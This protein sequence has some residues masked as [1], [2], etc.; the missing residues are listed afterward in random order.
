MNSNPEAL[1]IKPILLWLNVILS[2]VLLA[3]R[4]TAAA[5]EQN[6]FTAPKLVVQITIDQLR[7][8]A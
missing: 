2:V 5:T 1:K 8:L 4:S 6:A 7:V 3:A